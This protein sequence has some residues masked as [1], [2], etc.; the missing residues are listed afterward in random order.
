MRAKFKFSVIVVYTLAFILWASNAFAAPF[1]VPD[2]IA[3]KITYFKS[4]NDAD[5]QHRAKSLEQLISK[6][7]VL[8]SPTLTEALKSSDLSAA[9][10]QT[11]QK[12]SKGLFSV[13]ELKSLPHTAGG[14]SLGISAR[15][16]IYEMISERFDFLPWSYAYEDFKIDWH[17]VKNH[18]DVFLKKVEATG[19]PVVFL[20]PDLTLSY[21]GA[22]VTVDE[23]KWFLAD[24]KRMKN[25][26]FVFGA[27]SMVS[28]EL[29][30]LRIEASESKSTLR[31]LFLR[32]LGA[33]S[34]AYDSE[35]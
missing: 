21:K 34:T 6:L 33:E 31:A 26:Y 25:V 23:F 28:P 1:V 14:F 17:K 4:Q 30:A 27:Y 13:D 10:L 3:Q 16:G 24:V 8:R 20:V 35:L 12:N 15:D 22:S 32:A 9:I 19:K 29:E 11:L 7:Q 18:T 2:A 5:L